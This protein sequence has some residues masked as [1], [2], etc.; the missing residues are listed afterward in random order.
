MRRRICKTPSSL[1]LACRSHSNTVGSSA[2]FVTSTTTTTTTTTSSSSLN[3]FA[4]VTSARDALAL[5]SVA[6][7]A[8][9]LI[10][11]T[12]SISSGIDESIIRN[13]STWDVL[14]DTVK[15]L[16]ATRKPWG[17]NLIVSV[18]ERASALST[19]SS[20]SS[21][22]A[23]IFDRIVKP[24]VT[25]EF[26]R[27][28][29]FVRSMNNAT[30]NN[31]SFSPP[32]SL[33]AVSPNDF[34]RIVDAL[35]TLGKNGVIV[36]T[37]D[38]MLF[39]Y[40]AINGAF[41]RGI[42]KM[43]GSLRNVRSRALIRLL[44]SG[45]RLEI[46]SRRGFTYKGEESIWD[47]I[48][49][50]ADNRLSELLNGTLNN[51]IHLSKDALSRSTFCWVSNA[52]Q[53]LAF[54]SIA[55]ELTA[56]L[57][58]TTS[59][60][61]YSRTSW[62]AS[63][64][65][66]ICSSSISTLIDALQNE[67]ILKS[68][69]SP[70]DDEQLSEIQKVKESALALLYAALDRASSDGGLLRAAR[71]M[72]SYWTGKAT[73]SSAD[74]QGGAQG[75][76]SSSSG[77]DTENKSR[78][79]PK[80][81][82]KILSEGSYTS[83]SS[84]SP[85]SPEVH[86]PDHAPASFADVWI[87][88]ILNAVS[89][90][91][92]LRIEK[93][94]AIAEAAFLAVAAC[95]TVQNAG[96][97]ST[98]LYALRH[99]EAARASSRDPNTIDWLA[100][101]AIEPG[102]AARRSNRWTNPS[103]DIDVVNDDSTGR[104]HPKYKTLARTFRT[105]PELLGSFLFASRSLQSLNNNV[106]R[107]T[108]YA[109]STCSND[110]LKVIENSARIL[111]PSCPPSYYI[112][113]ASSSSMGG[114]KWSN[115]RS[116]SALLAITEASALVSSSL[117]T[118]DGLDP[119]PDSRASQTF[120]PTSTES[121]GI[122]TTCRMIA[123]SALAPAPPAGSVHNKSF[124]D[125][126]VQATTAISSLEHATALLSSALSAGISS[127][128]PVPKA[129]DPHEYSRA[130]LLSIRAAESGEAKMEELLVP[131]PS[132]PTAAF[133][134]FVTVAAT[135][136]HRR[137]ESLY[138]VV[139][140][141][142]NDNSTPS[143]NVLSSKAPLN[144][145]SIP[146]EVEAE[147]PD[148]VRRARVL[149]SKIS[150]KHAGSKHRTFSTL[151]QKIT[152]GGG[153]GFGG[154]IVLP[155]LLKANVKIRRST[156]PQSI[157]PAAISSLFCAVSSLLG[158]A[159]GDVLR[160]SLLSASTCL[161][162]ADLILAKWKRRVAPQSQTVRGGLKASAF[163]TP[164]DTNFSHLT[165]SYHHLTLLAQDR[166][167]MSHEATTDALISILSTKNLNLDGDNKQGGPIASSPGM[168]GRF[169]EFGAAL[170]TR[171]CLKIPPLT[172]QNGLTVELERDLSL[173]SRLFAALLE[174]ESRCEHSFSVQES[175]AYAS[176]IFSD[177]IRQQGRGGGGEERNAQSGIYLPVTIAQG[178]RG[179]IDGGEK[180]L[181]R[182]QSKQGGWEMEKEQKRMVDAVEGM[183]REVERYLTFFP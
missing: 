136:I 26:D 169:I 121:S 22:S 168:N 109:T 89:V 148:L 163:E 129:I 127:R 145:T 154:K 152:R 18:L 69:S 84:S 3:S 54:E 111:N 55:A 134:P 11:A 125:D 112:T 110:F 12:A 100:V 15:T 49:H 37:N 31:R 150:L 175:L 74:T 33:V 66:S 27:G 139:V 88:Q 30:P 104:I 63:H 40:K 85:S 183:I 60:G 128:L 124:E 64:L 167:K 62:K 117:L 44:E 50:V 78:V 115:Q 106:T 177:L 174:S 2:P 28:D 165:P 137:L 155:S 96:A 162:Q 144:F 39:L 151:V 120:A 171:V 7:S 38:G 147:E 164:L 181:Y 140:D 32:G 105:S 36:N 130:V 179:I 10:Q 17:V 47:S 157:S 75:G 42:I 23:S 68:R 108:L 135:R 14:A 176:T 61:L 13:C 77:S 95:C 25:K 5:A 102:I 107:D 56:R 83:S 53:R 172:I 178:L 123:L 35:D 6:S 93:F 24:A 94:Q 21:S 20:S 72:Q 51:E 67:K 182:I 143:N 101:Q 8:T 58:A 59:S 57:T 156:S 126:D 132:V 98:G 29:A 90:V 41:N 45:D 73:L 160:G 16:Q 158:Q 48:A 1:L 9:S 138:S 180:F 141:D 65:G 166:D 76:G 86:S 4:S 173:A 97:L 159:N 46:M 170:L 91:A 114:G 82:L 119:K 131:S 19:I 80:A 161:M 71:S 116:A 52:N 122:Q 113:D 79:I 92:I 118:I 133:R 87:R 99:V 103:D 153:G 146:I 70:I 149:R 81:P 34:V 43:P 142:K